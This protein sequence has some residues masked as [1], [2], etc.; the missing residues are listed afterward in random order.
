MT[1]ELRRP[2]HTFEAGAY[3]ATQVRLYGI[4]GDLDIG[5]PGK[6]AEFSSERITVSVEPNAKVSKGDFEKFKDELA[7]LKKNFGKLLRLSASELRSRFASAGFPISL[8]NQLTIRTH[9]LGDVTIATASEFFGSRLTAGVI[10]AYAYEGHCYDLAKPKIMV[11]PTMWKIVTPDDD[12]GFDAKQNED[13]RVWVVDKLDRC[14]ELELNQGFV[15]Q[16][17]LDSNMPGK[18]SPRSYSAVMQLAHRSGRLT[19]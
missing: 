3:N 16:I 9:M 8:I 19:E 17:V 13:Y 11:L 1:T 6:P 14:A 5:F 2:T 18:R 15:E 7:E 10:Y 4:P 12:S